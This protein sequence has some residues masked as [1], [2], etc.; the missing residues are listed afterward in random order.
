M[1]ISAEPKEA[2]FGA[3]RAKA[4][5]DAVVAIAMTLLILPLME[6]VADVA[7]KGESAGGWVVGHTGQLFVF[8]LSFAVIALF[9]ISHQRVF[10]LVE[11]MSTLLLWITMAWL[12]SIVWM[13]VVTAMVGQMSN[14]RL[15]VSMYI[16][17]MIVTTT[18]GLVMILYLRAHPEMHEISRGRIL[19]WVAVDLAMILLFIV[20]LLVALL[21][22][23]V[24]YY[25]LCFMMLTYPVQLAFARLLDRRRVRPGDSRADDGERQ[26]SAR[27][28][29]LP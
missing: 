26:P 13:P 18:L 5:I 2:L 1:T 20:S 22:P 4:F 7:S 14:D 8:V 21:Q 28:G 19:R 16:G 6:S 25:T 11:R 9:W 10:T 29:S 24:S 3:A 17:S 27:P 23:A 12:L 15:L